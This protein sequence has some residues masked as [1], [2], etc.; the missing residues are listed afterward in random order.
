MTHDTSSFRASSALEAAR[1]YLRQGWAPIPVR[2]GE[3]RP[4]RGDW[5]HLR[6]EEEDLSAEFPEGTNVGV[7]LGEPSGGL[8]DVDLDTHEAINLAPHFLPATDA[9]FGRPSRPASHWLYVAAPPPRSAFFKI[10][11]GPSQAGKTDTTTIV[12]LR[13]TGL[14]TLLPPSQHEGDT[15][16]WY[17]EG[18]PAQV[19]ARAITT[20]VTH[21][22]AA[23]LLVRCWPGRGSRQDAA[24]ALAGGLARIGWPPEKIEDFI[25]V[26]ATAAGDE[27]AAKRAKAAQSTEKRLADEGPATGWP[28]L[29]EI[30]GEAATKTLTNWL[31]RGN[32][33]AGGGERMRAGH[34]PENKAGSQSQ[35]LVS[36]ALASDV[37][38]TPD[39][40][41]YASVRVNGHTETWPVRSKGFK[42]WLMHSFY[43]QEGKPA[44]NQAL[45]DALAQI[46]AQAR[47][48]GAEHPVFLRIAQLG[49]ALYVDLCNEAWEVVK[50]DA[51]GWEV[52]SDPP[53]HLRRSKG[54]MPLPR[55][56]A[57]G[58]VNLLR[59]YVNAAAQRTWVLMVA[60]L[61]GALRANGPFPI[62]ILEGEAGSAKSTVSRLLRMLVDPSAA[63]LRMLPR[64]ER[65][66]MICAQNSW[67]LNFDNLSPLN[68]YSSDALCR[69]A[70]GAGL[71][72][73]QLYSDSDEAISKRLAR[74]S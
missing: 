71:S 41:A 42:D 34:D 40:E 60:F 16:R 21:L 35:I 23:A 9:V 3:K 57:G 26:V 37:F 52:V 65:D 61:V 17:K 38:R 45:Q 66:L 5:T 36:I 22:A 70:T 31:R 1:E 46:E 28:R 11:T 63:P 67:L 6:L 8:I 39:G 72:T 29:A 55:P 4:V 51:D 12:E 73:R 15:R 47:F 2:P 27:E 25:T 30:I 49:S 64:D 50:V 53:V 43:S 7:L 33:S 13:G 56:V 48:D 32:H 20:A 58:S 62:L 18:T 14:Q 24:L 68:R 54:M 74:S 10:Q 44:G 19:D 59:Q 69:L